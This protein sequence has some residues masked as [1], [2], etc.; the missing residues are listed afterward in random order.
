M[1]A[2]WFLPESVIRVFLNVHQQVIIAF[3]M[4]AETV[5]VS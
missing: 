3:E 5:V 4:L 2:R 1:Y